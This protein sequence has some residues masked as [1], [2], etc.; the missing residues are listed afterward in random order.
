MSFLVNFWKGIVYRFRTWKL[1]RTIDVP[2]MDWTE[3]S[4]RQG[5]V[6]VVDARD[7]HEYAVSHLAGSLNIPYKQVRADP[8]ILQQVP[9]DRPVVTYCTIGWRSGMVASKLIQA[10][11]SDVYN[12]KGSLIHWFNMGGTVVKDDGE[13]VQRI[14]PFNDDWARYITRPMG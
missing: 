12:L 3:L 5:E 6:T 1:T 14:H 7:P 13:E 8:A 10:G 4:R 9:K 11:Y 2:K